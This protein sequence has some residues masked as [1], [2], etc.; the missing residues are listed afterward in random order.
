MTS[1]VVPIVY[2]LGLLE[3][4]KKTGVWD[5]SFR[6]ENLNKKINYFSVYFFIS[7]LVISFCY[8]KPLILIFIHNFGSVKHILIYGSCESLKIVSKKIFWT[9]PILLPN[10]GVNDIFIYLNDFNFT[11]EDVAPL[12][13][14]RPA[15][16]ERDNSPDYKRVLYSDEGYFNK[17]RYTNHVNNC[18]IQSAKDI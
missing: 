7:S 16:I 15:I 4:K 1:T 5:F 2:I 14:Y 3:I 10:Q 11:N 18:M 9:L 8:I 6:V 13:E 17:S 12:I